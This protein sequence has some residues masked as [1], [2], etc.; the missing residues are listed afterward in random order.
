MEQN[1]IKSGIDAGGTVAG[2]G[3]ALFQKNALSLAHLVTHAVLFYIHNAFGDKYQIMRRVAR[4][5]GVTL[6]GVGHI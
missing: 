5:W 6:Y 1:V 2:A 4:A 3:I